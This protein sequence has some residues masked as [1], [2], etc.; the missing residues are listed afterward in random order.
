MTSSF[1]YGTIR[2]N[3]CACLDMDRFCSFNN[4]DPIS[5]NWQLTLQVR[6]NVVGAFVEKQQYIQHA[7]IDHNKD[8][9]TC[10]NTN[11]LI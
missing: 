3:K 1:L 7:N 4:C 8:L 5:E 10:G 6:T 9:L 2:A 11:L